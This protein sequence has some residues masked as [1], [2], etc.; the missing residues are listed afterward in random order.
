M[1][2]YGEP[3]KLFDFQEDAV[4]KLLD[5]THGTGEQRIISVKSPTG[6]GKTVILVQYVETYF[7]SHIND[8]TAFIWLTPGAGNLEDQ[9]RATMS[10][11]APQLRTQDI[12]GALS[13]GFPPRTTTF[14][15][16]EM[17]INDNNIS[18]REGEQK[19][20]YDKIA[21][22]HREGTKFIIIIDEE[23][24]ND[25][26]KAQKILDAFSAMYT[27]RVSAT[28]RDNQMS[29]FYE[30][31]ELEVIKSGLIT[32]AIYVN[33]GLK[34]VTNKADETDSAI[35]LNLALAKREAIQKKY[36]ELGKKIRPLIIV[37]FPN[38][39]TR[40]IEEVERKL[41][42]SVIT[43]D[44]GLLAKWMSDDK[45][46]IENISDNNAAPIVLLMKQA[47][48]TGWDCP[49]AKILVKLRENTNESFQIQTIGR[50][51][52]MPEAKHYE[53]ELLDSCYVYT[54]DDR[55]KDG[56]LTT[57][58]RAYE[59]V[60]LFR[61]KECAS[62]SLTK[63]TL[64][65]NDTEIDD[66][67]VLCKIYEYYK[68]HY[69]LDGDYNKNKLKLERE[70]YIFDE[71]IILNNVEGKTRTINNISSNAMHNITLKR[72]LLVNQ[73][74]YELASVADTLRKV[75]GV[76]TRMVKNYLER[77]FNGSNK[78]LEHKLLK[79]E[80]DNFLLFILNNKEKIKEDFREVTAKNAKQ[81]LENISLVSTKFKIPEQDFY[82]YEPRC[83]DITNYT[84]NAFKDYTSGFVTTRVKSF[85]EHLFEKEC[86]TNE[87][88][89]WVYKNGDTG[90]RYFSI[91]Y[92]N[93]IGKQRL[94]YPDY[95]VKMKN[96]TIWII[97]TKGGETH[98]INQNIDLQ[99]SNKFVA[100]KRYVDSINNDNTNQKINWGIVRYIDSELYINNTEYVKEMS[101]EEGKKHWR[102]LKD[103]LK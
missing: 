91:V 56:L 97:E 101:S 32:K 9:S 16:W 100:L 86:E 62:F 39:N 70:G 22:A 59:T 57:L 98:G 26:S 96:G 2:K 31:D 76:Q 6:S 47:I 58:N 67:E 99:T 21:D 37:Q 19:N 36:D 74:G 94:F 28:A 80:P 29:L 44:N 71:D 24:K 33:E 92:L 54:F 72:K 79:L 11:F 68:E 42:E 64:A 41:F 84:K 75:L 73:H 78:Y 90:S 3:I 17:V 5:L 83:N 49:R 81:A 65:D 18:L 45:E 50:I 27:I 77:L 30:I 13:S 23:H 95:I 14:I 46:N 85:S 60:R 34:E 43:Y 66:R 82:K 52:R 15:N 4:K 93:G 20:L 48:S 69:K 7:R 38:A 103:V 51:R 10:N 40:L 61:K 12:F 102:P 53:D 1:V 63:Q 25:T 87:N 55:F 8:S 89:D 88:L 35:L